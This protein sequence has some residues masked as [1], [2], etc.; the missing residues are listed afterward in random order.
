MLYYFPHPNKVLYVLTIDGKIVCTATQHINNLAGLFFC[1]L[2]LYEEQNGLVLT[3]LKENLILLDESSTDQR[4]TEPKRRLG[5]V[6][7][8]QQRRIDLLPRRSLN[9]QARTEKSKGGKRTK[10]RKTMCRNNRLVFVDVG[11][12]PL[13]AS[14]PTYI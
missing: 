1:C 3:D 12:V 4:Q 14:D 10:E 13:P 6:F 7:W 8:V 2:L 9:L 11:C 5:P